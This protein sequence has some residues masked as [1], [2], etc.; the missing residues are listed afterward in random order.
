[1]RQLSGRLMVAQTPSNQQAQDDDRDG[2]HRPNGDKSCNGSTLRYFGAARCRAQEVHF[3]S[4]APR[5]GR[6][7]ELIIPPSR[8]TARGFGTVSDFG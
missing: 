5:R 8:T 3:T 4:I 7:I 2:N 1:M 6:W